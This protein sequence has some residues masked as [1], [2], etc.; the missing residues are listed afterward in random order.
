MEAK[1]N[2]PRIFH[3]KVNK[4]SHMCFVLSRLLLRS[5][6]E[7]RACRKWF[8]VFQLQLSLQESKVPT[9][10]IRSKLCVCLVVHMFDVSLCA[11]GRHAYVH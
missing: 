3:C 1:G 11:C 9:L 10:V 2:E 7:Q 4:L 6:H 5:L 8:R